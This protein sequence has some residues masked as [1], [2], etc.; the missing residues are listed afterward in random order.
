MYSRLIKKTKKLKMALLTPGLEYQVLLLTAFNTR[1][2]EAFI[3]KGPTGNAVAHSSG[4]LPL[5]GFPGGASVFT[6]ILSEAYPDAAVH[7]SQTGTQTVGGTAF[8]SLS[9]VRWLSLP[10]RTSF[11]HFGDISY[12]V[13]D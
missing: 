4:R 5:G 6:T 11:V 7:H 1:L 12:N 13:G 2:I 9:A 3:L 8:S 10:V